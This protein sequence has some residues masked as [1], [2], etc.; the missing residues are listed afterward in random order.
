MKEKTATIAE[1]MQM[2]N[3]V[4]I[5]PDGSIKKKEPCELTPEQ[6][7]AVDALPVKRSPSYY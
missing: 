3:N 5:E 4:R 2:G 1:L 6:Q 7:E